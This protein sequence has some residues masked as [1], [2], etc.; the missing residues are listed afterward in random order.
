MVERLHLVQ[1]VLVSHD[2]GAAYG[3]ADYCRSG[4]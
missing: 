2:A 1:R 3:A 4:S